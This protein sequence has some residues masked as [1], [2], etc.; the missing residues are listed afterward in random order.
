MADLGTIRG[1]IRLDVRQA[2]A[3]YAAVR[4]QNQRTV[5]AL[6]GTGDSFVQAGKTMGVAGAGM[7]Y[8]FGKIVKAAADFERKMDFFQAVSGTN[9]AAMEKL[10]DYTL[11]LAQDTIYSAEQ[12]ADGLIE[13]GKSGVSAEQIMGGVGDAMAN[14]GAAGDIPLAESGQIITSTIQQFDMAAKDAVGVTDLLAGAA[15]ASIADITDLGVSLKYA[16]GV[17]NAAGLDFEDTIVAISLLAKAGIRGST[18][19]TSLRQMMV[20]FGGATKPAR[21]AL[22]ELGILSYDLA[23]ANKTLAKVTG[24]EAKSSIEAVQAELGKYVESIDGG[25][26]G[27]NK[28]A[29]AVKDLMMKYGG[30]NNKFY[31]SEGRLKKMS[32]VFQILQ[33]SLKGY[34][35]RTKLAYLRTLFN[36]R[37]LS[38]AAILTRDGAKGFKVMNREMLKVK[39][40]EVARDR[41]DNLSGDIEILRGNIETWMTKAGGPFQETLRGWVQNL[42]KL[43]QKFDELDP[44]VQKGVIQFL[45]VG[46]VALVAMG[47]I[48]IFIGTIF[49]FIAAMLKMAAG[50]SF[51]FKHLKN[52]WVW[53]RLLASVFGS[54]LVGAIGAIT[55]PV[56]AVIAAVVAL[57]AGLVIAYKK[58]ETFRNIVNRVAGA[59]WG[60]I[61]A[62]GR[63]IKLLATDPSAAWAKLKSGVTK[64]LTYVRNQFAKLPGWIEAQFN[65][66]KAKIQGWVN[67]A[68]A[69]FSRLPGMIAGGLAALGSAIMGFFQ[70][71]PGRVGYAIGFLIG[72]VIKQFLLLPLRIMALLVKFSTSMIGLF[73]TWAPKI[74]Y[75]VGLLIGKVIGFFLR[76][77]IRIGIATGKM[78]LGVINWFR[79]LPGRVAAFVLRMY[80]RAVEL[81]NKVKNDGPRIM[82]EAIAGII[83]WFRTLPERLATW[84][85][86][87]ALLIDRKLDSMRDKMIKMAIKML[88]GFIRGIKGLPEKVGEI[89]DNMIQMVKDAAGKAKDA[90]FDFASGMWEGF[91]DGLG[92]HSPSHMERAMWQITGVI[93][94]ET[95]KIAKRTMDVQKLSKKMAA[96]QFGVGGS[97]PDLPSR[98]GYI[99]LASMHSRN[100]NRSRTLLEGAGKRTD[101]ASSGATTKTVKIET[102]VNNPKP[103]RASQ[104]QSKILRTAAEEAGWV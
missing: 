69:W 39:A 29:D 14:L 85:V 104:S 79:K 17:A 16:G 94:E 101:R 70:K 98:R 19:G 53:A 9:S 80:N 71:L 50:M 52:I 54:A 48:S 61:K 26:V 100:Q 43:I 4:A 33:D 28:N 87:T 58:S 37:A 96:T 67:G 13:L 46:G 102:T 68:K 95:K 3:A 30:L 89:T 21:A 103:E 99:G 22:E 97:A 7:I 32:S 73:A 20:S 38:A 27:T 78:I 56:W 75:L 40:A 65:K 63:W 25:T 44:A 1:Q 81:F 23:T 55:A 31:D 49:R 18:A 24:G 34:D 66:A 57:I 10:G 86:K 5:Y 59:L 11:K 42:T 76:M 83:N 77:G 2:V 92:I 93:D 82:A 74:G 41:L 8:L 12:I 47:A 84:L 15:N 60:A 51:L 90:I 6:R 64:A 62:I 45:G 36:N 88:N 72:F 91:K 35:N